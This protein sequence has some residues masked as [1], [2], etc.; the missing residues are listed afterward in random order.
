VLALDADTWGLLRG[1]RVA[2]DL[3][4]VVELAGVAGGLGWLER[5]G[6]GAALVATGS[7][8]GAV[9]GRHA[10]AHVMV[11]SGAVGG[12]TAAP[13]QASAAGT[14]P[15][16]RPQPHQ[17]QHRPVPACGGC[18]AAICGWWVESDSDAG[19]RIG[20]IRRSDGLGIVVAVGVGAAERRRAHDSS[21]PS[22]SSTN[23]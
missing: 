6:L 20:A 18:D 11:R 17:V 21:R 15:P 22:A 3:L 13:D 16:P 10:S 5:R 19:P 12:V 2:P 14:R 9:A 1:S 7:V 23:R 4:E 8:E